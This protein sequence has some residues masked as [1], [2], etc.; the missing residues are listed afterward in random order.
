MIF[1][2][3]IVPGVETVGS[4]TNGLNWLLFVSI[5]ASSTDALGRMTPVDT[6][7]SPT[8]AG[9]DPV[10][11]CGILPLFTTEERVI[12]AEEPTGAGVATASTAVPS[13]ILV[14]II[15]ESSAASGKTDTPPLNVL[16]VDGVDGIL[17][18]FG[19]GTGVGVALL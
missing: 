4:S 7:T 1:V 15:F 11:S 5:F 2:D 8:V 17:T 3:G 10:I 9:T 14:K 6:G 12:P 16:L 19:T 13:V 18:V